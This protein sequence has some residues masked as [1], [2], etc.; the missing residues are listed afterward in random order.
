MTDLGRP[1]TDPSSETKSVNS[2]GEIVSGDFGVTDR[3]S[4]PF[5]ISVAV[6]Q[7]NSGYDAR[8]VAAQKH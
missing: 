7:R 1:S 6:V 4:V 2:Q 5:A 8:R 3:A